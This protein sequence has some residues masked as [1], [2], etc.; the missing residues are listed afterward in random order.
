MSYQS[1]K[2]KVRSMPKVHGDGKSSVRKH[3]ASA[4]AKRPTHETKR[5]VKE[6]NTGL[7]IVIF[8][9][10]ALVVAAVA[11]DGFKNIIKD[12]ENPANPVAAGK[13]GTAKL[14]FYVMSQCPY[15]TQVEDAIAPVLAKLGD[16]VDFNL[17]FI[18]T[19]LG[20]G[21]FKSLHGE[22]ETKGNIV[23]LCAIKYN[24]DKYMD[25]IICQNKN[26]GQIPGNWESCASDNGLE[27]AKIKACYEGEE[28]KELLRESIARTE[29]VGAS[30]SPTIY[31]NDKP[32]QSARDTLSFLKAV[33]SQLEGHPEC[34]ELPKCSTNADCTAEV[35]KNG[36]CENPGEKDSK[37]TYTDPVKV[38]VRVLVDENCKT[39]DPD[40]INEITR[41]LFKGANFGEV[42]FDSAEGQKM[43]KDYGIVFLPAFVFDA[44]IEDTETWTAE[45]RIQ[46]SFVKNSDGTYM[47]NAQAV[48]STWDPYQEVCDNGKDDND[49]GKTDCE[50]EKC[51]GTMAC[52]EK[53]EIPKVEI[54]VMSHC[55]YGTQFEKGALPVLRLLDDKVDYDV[56]FVYYAMHG[57][58]ELDEQML[59]YCIQTEEKAKYLDYLE[60]FLEDGDTARCLGVVGL[61]QAGL[62]PC[63][64]DTDAEYKITEQFNDKSTWQG[65]Q[66]PKFDISADLNEKYGIGG[67]PSWVVN[68]VNMETGRDSASIL[69][70]I[71]YGFDEK[72]AECD[73]VLSSASPSAGFGTAAA[74]ASS[75]TA[76]AAGSCG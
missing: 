23:Q 57:K 62:Q 32:Y 39:C 15:G 8:I 75:G 6:N 48:G 20:D 9:L 60:C 3:T 69:E 33:C 45:P 71:C 68:G 73:E 18:S 50:D 64:D 40:R 5:V 14:D 4:H 43:M 19:D 72:P 13:Y 24:P 59:Q 56:N 61:T 34:A 1:R 41:S 63:I 7:W 36:V 22:P 67:S 46:G 17:D 37:C 66:F 53:M 29:K 54:F 2:K 70:A 11:T 58:K 27:V 76:A 74:S 52:M 12:K 44:E 30:G 47:L 21:T 49:N 25:M 10:G 51:Q 42:K 65:G 55:P 16:S 38:D 26:A 28:G 31:L 35:D